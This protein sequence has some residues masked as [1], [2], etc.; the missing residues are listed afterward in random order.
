MNYATCQVL[1]QMGRLGNQLFQ[2]A[3][4]IS[5]AIDHGKEYCFPRWDYQE[6]INLPLGV[7]KHDVQ[8]SEN[9]LRYT[10]FPHVEGNVNLHG[11]FLS[12]KYFQHNKHH[13]VRAFEIP[14][15]MRPKT[16]MLTYFTD[17][18]HP[19]SLNEEFPAPRET[20]GIHIRRGDYLNPEQLA[21][22]GVM[23]VDYYNKAIEIMRSKLHNPLFFI[24]SDDL[25]WAAENFPRCYVIRNTKDIHDMWL[26]SKMK[27]NIISNSTFG[28][29]GAYLNQNRN[30]TVIA[31]RQWFKET[32]GWDDLY[33]PNWI[34]L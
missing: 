3:T 5:Y 18:T 26:L 1:G 32:K 14:H 31:P 25:N 30:N 15:N 8:L 28:W 16:S 6:Y 21:A 23:G 22:H 10:E 29:W 33:E 24:V 7:I 19:E 9:S 17:H 2:V 11:H 4:T 27:H 12:T 13:I 34:K 20:V